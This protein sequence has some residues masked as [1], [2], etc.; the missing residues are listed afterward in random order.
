MLLSANCLMVEHQTGQ[1]LDSQ[2]VQS[3]SYHINLTEKRNPND[4]LTTVCVWQEFP[5]SGEEC[6]IWQ[7]LIVVGNAGFRRSQGGDKT[8]A[9]R[10]I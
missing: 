5:S 7:K 2:A 4:M 1:L 3:P 8:V 10:A 9:A 6:S